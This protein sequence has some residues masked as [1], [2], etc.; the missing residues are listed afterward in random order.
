M[1][2]HM[3]CSLFCIVLGGVFVASDN[4]VYP[5]LLGH[6]M[7]KP[8]TIFWFLLYTFGDPFALHVS[9]VPYVPC[10]DVIHKCCLIMFFSGIF[11]LEFGFQI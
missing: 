9:L 3:I 4:G 7:D 6:V 10:F 1:F 8:D 11:V 5:I 2:W